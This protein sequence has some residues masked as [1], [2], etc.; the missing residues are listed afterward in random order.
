MG[1]SRRA[2][3]VGAIHEQKLLRQREAYLAAAKAV[4]AERLQLQHTAQ[5]SK[6]REDAAAGATLRRR[7]LELRQRFSPRLE[8]RRCKLK[9][10][11]DNEHAEAETALQQLQDNAPTR[12]K[13]ILQRATALKQKHDQQR[14]KEDERL[15]A[16]RLKQER[17]DL[18]L[19]E[20]KQL[21]EEV[22]YH[23]LLLSALVGS[24]ANK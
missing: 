14:D 3:V 19:Q 2:A 1:L 8:E 16:L 9:A 6:R 23:I 4:L 22:T 24:C 5:V 17:G 10:L 11:L 15:L 18:R 21:V 12:E 13:A 7:V 20:H